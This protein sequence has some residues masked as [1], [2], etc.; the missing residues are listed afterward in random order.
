MVSG[1]CSVLCAHASPDID[2]KNIRQAAI[3]WLRR[4]VTAHPISTTTSDFLHIGRI[5][6]TRYSSDA[7]SAICI[8]QPVEKKPP[9]GS[10]QEK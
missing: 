6:A 2:S 4:V 1:A 8:S 9:T 7:S 3:D 10:Y 5:D